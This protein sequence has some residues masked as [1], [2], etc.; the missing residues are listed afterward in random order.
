MLNTT[1]KTPFIADYAETSSWRR[2][3]YVSE[4]D[5]FV[6]MYV[7]FIYSRCLPIYNFKNK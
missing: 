2:N 3:L 1:L 6:S 7:I 4:T 5:L